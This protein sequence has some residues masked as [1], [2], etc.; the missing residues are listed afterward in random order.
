MSNKI[1]RH[2]MAF[3]FFLVLISYPLAAQQNARSSMTYIAEVKGR[4][5]NIGI[6]SDGSYS[7]IH[8]GKPGTVLRSSVEADTESGVLRSSA[9]PQHKTVLS[10]I[11]DQF[12]SGMQLQVT[13]TGLP[14]TPGHGV[15]WE[16][17]V[18]HYR[19]PKQGGALRGDRSEQESKDQFKM[20]Y[21]K[22]LATTVG[23][24]GEFPIT[25]VCSTN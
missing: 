24:S 25:F 13:H 3:V 10:D 8:A 22:S 14:A 17:P 5:M 19:R 15:G 11:Q 2:C 16:K 18:I 1:S 20:L 9:Y 21:Q 4:V 12:G 7:L 23:C 6:D